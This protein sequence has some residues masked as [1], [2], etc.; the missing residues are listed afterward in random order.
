[1]SNPSPSEDP[2]IPPPRSAT[3]T[4]RIGIF[5]GAIGAIVLLTAGIAALVARVNPPTSTSTPVSSLGCPLPDTHPTWTTTPDVTIVTADGNTITNVHVGQ[6][7]EVDLS[8]T[9][10]WRLMTNVS[11]LVQ[12]QNPA[13][14]F[15][16]ARQLCVWRFTVAQA[17][18]G[19]L[20]FERRLICEP[21][22][23]CSDLIIYYQF[24]IHATN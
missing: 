18:D 12:V 20:P 3:L 11:S 21:G 15:D 7:I 24:A 8:A 17:G 13:G 10:R 1:M 19:M 4:R 22:K 23:L 16:A 9:Y 14:A 5:G 2:I 6:T